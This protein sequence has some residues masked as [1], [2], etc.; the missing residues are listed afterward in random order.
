MTGLEDFDILLTHNFCMRLKI[1]LILPVLAIIGFF[2][3]RP[4]ISILGEKIVAPTETTT[5]SASEP[6][7]SKFTFETHTIAEGDTFGI[8]TTALG[9]P[10]G[11]MLQILDAASSTYDF[12]SVK[13]GQPLTLAKNLDGTFAYLDY[14]RNKDLLVR[15]YFAE[16]RSEIIPIQYEVEEVIV[17]GVVSSSLYLDALAMGVPDAVIMQFADTFAWTIDFSTQVQHGDSFSIIYEKRTR[18]GKDAGTGLVRAGKFVNGGEVLYGFLYEQKE[19]EPSYFNEKGESLV[20]QFLRAPLEYKRI[21]SGYT[22]AR[23]HPILGKNTTHMAIDYAAAIG[24]P[25]MA[26]GDGVVVFTG[27]H[28]AYGNFVNIKHNDQ[29]KTQY[30]HMSAFAKGI[31]AGVRV[32][33]GQVIGY[34]G[35]TGLSTGP[36]LH[37]Q[38]EEYGKLINPLKVKFPPGEPISKEHASDFQEVVNKFKDQL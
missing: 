13:V 4:K 18:D 24:T 29:F 15:F 16:G 37:Y 21:T 9:I 35:T 32:T 26:V 11:Q 36:H 34:V 14:E 1:L 38:I 31:K 19:G 20:K 33:Q 28:G 17:K 27:Y 8:A 6:E 22:T 5:V 10:Y 12:T 7:K 3:F 23:F 30:A 2:I 25:I